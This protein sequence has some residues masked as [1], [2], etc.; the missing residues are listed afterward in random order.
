MVLSNI[1]DNWTNKNSDT[2]VSCFRTRE[3]LCEESPSSREGLDVMASAITNAGLLRCDNIFGLFRLLVQG[4]INGIFE[5]S[6]RGYV[7]ML[8]I[9]RWAAANKVCDDGLNVSLRHLCESISVPGRLI[10]QATRHTELLEQF[11][12]RQSGNITGD[13]TTEGAEEL[14]LILE[15]VDIL[16]E[17]NIL[18]RLFEKQIS[19]AT[20]LPG[21]ECYLHFEGVAN[22]L[23]ALVAET[24]QLHGEV[25]QTH[26]LVSCIHLN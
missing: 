17:L 9:Y 3:P 10:M 16:D 21:M 13:L 4:S 1:H 20:A 24:K 19:V 2:L 26:Q 7:D 8:S 11:S 15:V 18:M 22:R 23:E 25:T 14:N 5:E 12:K 6:R